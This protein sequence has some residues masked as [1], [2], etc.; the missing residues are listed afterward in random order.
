MRQVQSSCESRHLFGFSEM[1]S[2]VQAQ[3]QNNSGKAQGS[4][5]ELKPSSLARQ[6]RSPVRCLT[7]LPLTALLTSVWSQVTGPHWIR[8]ALEHKQTKPSWGVAKPVDALRTKN[9]GIIRPVAPLGPT[10]GPAQ[11]RLRILNK[12]FSSCYRKAKLDLQIHKCIKILNAT[13]V[14]CETFIT[15]TY[16]QVSSG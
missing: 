15:P 2:W 12:A 1:H 5:A 13:Q 3:L 16:L 4:G 9:L 7:A 10:R 6:E 14:S 8:A 11:G